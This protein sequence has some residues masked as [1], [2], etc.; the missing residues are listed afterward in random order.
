MLVFSTLDSRRK[1]RMVLSQTARSH[2][3]FGKAVS[4]W[5]WQRTRSVGIRCF[6]ASVREEVTIGTEKSVRRRN[7]VTMGW[8]GAAWGIGGVSGAV[9]WE[10]CTG[11]VVMVGFAECGGKWGCSRDARSYLSVLMTPELHST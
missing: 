6:Q 10:Y 2:Q 5:M 11:R 1:R 8:W 9:G 4:L 7:S 3:I